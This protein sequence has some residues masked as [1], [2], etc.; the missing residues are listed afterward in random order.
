MPALVDAHCHITYGDANSNEELAFYT[1]PEFGA[2]RAA[3]NCK[4]VLRAGVTTISEPNSV[5]N[6]GAALR[7]AIACGMVQ[8]P[9][10]ITAGAALVT[11]HGTGLPSRLRGFSLVAVVESAE[12][13]VK[14]IRRQFNEGA[15][16]IKL[17]GSAEVTTGNAS[18]GGGELITFSPRELS[19][20]VEEAHR[21]GLKV[22][23]HARA[24]KAASEAA[25]AGADWIFHCSFMT[26]QDLDVV[27]K[28]GA[29]IL[30]TLTYLANMADWGMKVGV[31]PMLSDL[32][33]LELKAASRILSRAHEMG[34]PMMI[35]SEA[36]FT[37]TP[38]GEWHAREMELFVQYVGYSPTEALVGMTKRN[39]E[40]LGF[41]GLG[42]LEPGKVGDIIIVEG[43]P[44]S[45]IRVLQDKS[46]ILTVIKEGQVQDTSGAEVERPIMPYEVTHPLSLQRLTVEKAY[47]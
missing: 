37:V 35:G 39:A 22:A 42:V 27:L 31:S 3:W 28:S 14:E 18:P 13:G 38:Y 45:D 34:A 8:G 10:M 47:D 1:A 4:R 43:N 29:V 16:F 20:M 24:G 23:V 36:G 17:I 25:R 21:L 6:I 46:K 44:V 12:D 26:E 33:Q 41:G 19:V 11:P 7:D 32:C 2:L 5:H 30:P 9:R 15:N 40:L